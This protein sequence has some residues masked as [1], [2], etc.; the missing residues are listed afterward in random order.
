[1][2][3]SSL[4][5]LVQVAIT[6]LVAALLHELTGVMA[7]R[8]LVYW[9]RAWLA[10]GVSLISV[11]V[12]MRIDSTYGTGTAISVVLLI[13]YSLTEYIFGFFLWIGCRNYRNGALFT[14]RDLRYFLPFAFAAVI[15][16]L[17][18]P[19]INDLFPVHSGVMAIWFCASA[20]ACRRKSL[21]VP[22]LLGMR[23]LRISLY[24]LT[25]LFL[26]YA[27]LVGWFCYHYPHIRFVHM[28]FSS[29]Y[30]A[31]FEVGMAFG[32]IL[33]ATERVRY[34]LEE[35]NRMLAIVTE[36][37]QKAALTD[38]LTGLLNRRAYDRLASD[39]ITT[40]GSIGI[41]DLNDMKPINDEYGHAVGDVALQ[42]VARSL[43]IH[44]RVTD[45]LF[46]MGGDEFAVV[47]P[48]CPA[49]E[50]AYRLGKIEEG[51]R[52][53][54]IAGVE[55]PIDLSISWGVAAFDSTCSF[56]DASAKAD[57]RMYA[58][59]KK[60]KGTVRSNSSVISV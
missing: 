33:L 41:I 11:V 46:R 19:N 20:I 18:F 22:M 6:L 57:E 8:F 39:P 32:M 2:E 44:F 47:M 52:S 17:R 60:R 50:M 54:R 31:A 49:E 5:A 35:R 23:L 36:E 37:L 4:T 10:L 25:V 55:R 48:T 43:R 1:M 21:A 59:K 45:P 38:P 13:L 56:L 28:E 34:E 29:L 15:L 42:L 3:L 53:Q 26:H 14:R 7:A 30:D 58:Q 27:I 12:A 9:S 24:G 40:G 51:L 16:P